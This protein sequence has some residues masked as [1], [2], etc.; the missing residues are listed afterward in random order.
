MVFSGLYKINIEETTSN[1]VSC[2]IRFDKIIITALIR[3]LFQSTRSYI[4]GIVV[5]SRPA[6]LCLVNSCNVS[7][8]MKFLIRR[9]ILSWL[10]NSNLKFIIFANLKPKIWER[11]FINPFVLGTKYYL[12]PISSPILPYCEYNWVHL[13]QNTYSPLRTTDRRKY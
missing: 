10:Y 1:T 9:G 2:L 6:I 4:K 8:F 7:V 13:T 5:Y 12:S 11:N 3:N